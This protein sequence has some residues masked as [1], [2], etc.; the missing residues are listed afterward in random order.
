MELPRLAG[1][2]DEEMRFLF[3]KKQ[4]QFQRGVSTVWILFCK[5]V[6]W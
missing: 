1:G 2:I 6:F 5:F 4:K 3:T